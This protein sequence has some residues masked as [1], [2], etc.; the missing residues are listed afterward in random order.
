MLEKIVTI[1]SGCIKLGLVGDDEPFWNQIEDLLAA[2]KPCKITSDILQK[3]KLTISDVYK[4]WFNCIL[5]TSK[6]G[7]CIVLVRL[8]Q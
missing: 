4:V 7:K 8:L 6:I 2:L 1:K 5:E 3:E